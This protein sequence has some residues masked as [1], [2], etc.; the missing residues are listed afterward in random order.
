[1]K[2][3]G[4][5]G[6]SGS[7]GSGSGTPATPRIPTMDEIKDAFG[8]SGSQ[9]SGGG[10]PAAGMPGGSGSGSTTPKMPGGFP[11]TGK[12]ATM[13]DVLSELTG[14]PAKDL[15]KALQD[16]KI[17]TPPGQAEPTLAD[18]LSQLTG[19]PV[20]QMP[21]KLKNMPLSEAFGPNSPLGLG[22]KDS[23]LSQLLGGDKPGGGGLGEAIGKLFDA[24]GQGLQAFAQLG[25][26]LPG[27]E[28]LQS[29]LDPAKIEDH[30]DGML[31][32][33]GKL[34]ELKS[35]LGLGGGGGGG[36]GGGGGGA[37]IPSYEQPLPSYA[38]ARAMDA[39]PRASLDPGA[40]T[41]A[42]ST[43]QNGMPPGSPMMGG[44]HPG[45]GAGSQGGAGNEHKPA[46]F[47]QSRANL[48]EVFDA[49]PDRV[50]P[51]IEP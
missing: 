30:I 13:A 19:I 48:D 29:L 27:M 33:E 6:G 37:G 41:T 22:G 40:M 12:P 16:M 25:G 1:S 9:G 49:V 42:G 38:E 14:V 2:P 21:D 43:G 4:S 5:S 7:Q 28:E 17:D 50:R 20:D 39:F 11:G 24:V 45:G 23:P 31:G 47:L 32:G 26:N 10:I 35:A 46:R 34:D 36:V 18:A 44:G 15:P 3:A 8:G 51:V